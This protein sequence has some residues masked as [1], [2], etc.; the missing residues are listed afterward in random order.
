[1]NT[2]II[3]HG[4]VLILLALISGLFIQAMPIPR[5][6]LSAHTIGILSGVLLLAIGAVWPSFVLSVRQKAAHVL[7]VG[8]LELYE[9]AGLLARCRDGSRQVDT[10]C[11]G[12]RFGS[13]C[14]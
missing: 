12:R 10:N 6:G 9:L 2:G 1:M 7:V 5:L 11:I 3:R 8:V 14:G 13:S 4:F